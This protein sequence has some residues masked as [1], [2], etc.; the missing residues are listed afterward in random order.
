MKSMYKG[1]VAFIVLAVLMSTGYKKDEPIIQMKAPQLIGEYE[2]ICSFNEKVK[3]DAS[4]VPDKYTLKIS[5]RDV[6]TISKN[7]KR[8]KKCHFSTVEVPV[9]YDYDFIM[10][11]EKDQFYPMFYKGDTVVQHLIPF[12]FQDNYFRKIR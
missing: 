4:A 6:L 5:K 7:G 8:L 1:V 12:E 3:T 10:F 9:T 2:Y 11:H